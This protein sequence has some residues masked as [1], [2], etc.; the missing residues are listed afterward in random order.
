M[1]ALVVCRKVGLVVVRS[2]Y[3]NH[4][5]A[6]SFLCLCLY[7]FDLPSVPWLIGLFLFSSMC[8][9]RQMTQQAQVGVVMGHSSSGLFTA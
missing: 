3:N 7:P 4:T 2:H 5:E 1:P 9:W 6:V 8:I